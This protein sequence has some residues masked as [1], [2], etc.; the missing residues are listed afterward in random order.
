M[1]GA[2]ISH[3]CIPSGKT[4]SLLLKARPSIKVKVK[5]QSHVVFFPLRAFAGAF[6]FH[7]NMLV[8]FYKLCL[9]I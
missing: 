5:Y 2:F 4:F 1:I 8:F 3:M 7:K 9:S 6:V